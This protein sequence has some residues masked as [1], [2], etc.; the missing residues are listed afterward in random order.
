MNESMEAYEAEHELIDAGPNQL[1]SG[2]HAAE[3][4][5][6]KVDRTGSKSS[7]AAPEGRIEPNPSPI[8]MEAGAPAPS[9]PAS[10]SVL[11][12]VASEGGSEG[13]SPSWEE[14]QLAA[15]NQALD[16][17]DRARLLAAK[18]QERI[19]GGEQRLPVAASR[20]QEEEQLQEKSEREKSEREEDSSDS[21]SSL[22]L[23][24]PPT[25]MARPSLASTSNAGGSHAVQQP[26]GSG[27][28]ADTSSRYHVPQ[29][30]S[31]EILTD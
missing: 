29:S 11:E 18:E 26:V 1:Q 7:A 20:Q 5:H 17:A 27:S 24:S 21:D 16:R 3:G 23:G 14:Q 6:A 12:D 22:G 28:S 25:P 15:F 13:G 2:S 31:R 10:G 4:A 8:S 9:A 30:S 19:E